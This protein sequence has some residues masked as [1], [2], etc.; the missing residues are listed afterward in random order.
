M[1]IR[2]FIIVLLISVEVI[3]GVEK[4][5]ENDE[6][7]FVPTEEWKPIRKGQKIPE[8]L[9]IRINLETGVTEAK[10]L[11]RIEKPDENALSVSPAHAH[12][13]EATNDKLKISPSELKQ[14]LK[15]IKNDI[16]EEEVKGKYRSY[17]EL[18][19]DFDELNVRPKTDVEILKELLNRHDQLIER[20]EIDEQE[21]LTVIEDLEYLVHQY[22]NAKEFV[23]LNGLENIV[24]KGLNSS[25]VEIRKENLKLLGA[26]VQNNAF[27]KT[28]AL[29]SGCIDVLCYEIFHLHNQ[30]LSKMQV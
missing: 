5:D 4:E 27:V 1:N 25:N 19:K 28:R 30:N 14:A 2:I 16:N 3:L 8:G 10:L 26:C 23:V 6:D 22:D 21:I 17:D 7:T 20:K 13:G 12:E 18:R 9:H 11:K 15:N 24:Y 29:D